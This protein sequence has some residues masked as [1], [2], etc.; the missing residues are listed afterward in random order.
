MRIA[1][2]TNNYKPFV[3]GVPISIERLAEGL[4]SLGHEVFIFAPTYG[5]SERDDDVIRYKSLKR[6]LGQGGMVI[7]NMFDPN[8]E[9]K[10]KKLNIDMIH[11]HHPMII[12]NIALYLGK[13]Y[14]VP[15][16]FTYHTRYEQY[17]HYIKPYEY[18]EYK[19]KNTRNNDIRELELK[20]LN[21]T[22]EK[23]VPN[24]IKGFADKC[25]IVFSPTESMKEYLMGIGVSSRIQIMPTGLKDQYF[26]KNNISSSDIRETYKKDKKYLFCT[27]ARL[28]KEKNMEF[29][30]DG[31]RKIKD[32][33][34]DCFNCLIIGDGPLKETL[35]EK[36]R[37]LNLQENITFLSTIKNEVISDY[38]KACDLFLFASKSETQGIVLLE[39]MAAENP[40]V[41]VKGTGVL[42]VVYD[43][44]NGYATEENLEEWSCKVINILKD[45]NLRNTLKKGAYDTALNYRSSNIARIAERNYEDLLR[46]YYNKECL[47]GD[48]V[49]VG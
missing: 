46:T 35:K 29:L 43:G 18:L 4:K 16:A 8:I 15:V 9:R 36:A 2:M 33:I 20:I 30:I 23:I 31:L 40:V 5:N 47:Y 45:E 3:G 49:H 37:D 17:L 14:D 48:K 39:A 27:V 7:P 13:K 6:K 34:G 21:S 25:D 10:F 41:A 32:N 19:S 44:I 26:S 24:Y 11:V 42:D 22:R 28:T 12:G 38:Y 1:M